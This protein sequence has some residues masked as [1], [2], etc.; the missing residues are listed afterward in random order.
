MLFYKISG[1]RQGLRYPNYPP[2]YHVYLPIAHS[3]I[4]T[5]VSR[6]PAVQ[7]VS[8]DRGQGKQGIR[9]QEVGA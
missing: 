3:I 6:K 5:A 4:S 2:R 8:G 7:N 1:E 9:K